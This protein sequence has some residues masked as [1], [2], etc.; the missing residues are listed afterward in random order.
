[1]LASEDC[2]IAMPGVLSYWRSHHAKRAAKLRR[3][4]AGNL[5]STHFFPLARIKSHCVTVLCRPTFFHWL[6]RGCVPYYAV[7]RTELCIVTIKSDKLQV[8]P[9]QFRVKY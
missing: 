6:L 7:E 9:R 2:G 1:M 8:Q 5:T 3:I 4:L